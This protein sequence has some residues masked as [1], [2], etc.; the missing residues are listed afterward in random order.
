MR[1]DGLKY[2]ICVGPQLGDDG[3]VTGN[4]YVD[5]FGL[6]DV[7]F[8]FITGV[9]DAD[10]GSTLATT[11][12]LIEQ[13]DTTNGEYTAVPSAALSDVIQDT[14]SNTLRAIRVDLT[15]AHKRYMKVQTPA[16]ANGTTGSNLAVIWVGDPAGKPESAADRGLV[17][18]VC[19]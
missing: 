16:V 18:Y 2:G 12:P 8:L 13:C 5:L 11:P 3:E 19:A 17:E 15:K 10:I 6:S 4:S 14:E 1:I 9:M 7:M